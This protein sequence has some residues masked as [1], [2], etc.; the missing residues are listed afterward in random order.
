MSI[1]NTSLAPA[2][3]HQDPTVHA[4][5]TNLTD[6]VIRI[7]L[8]N[9]SPPSSQD[10]TYYDDEFVRNLISADILRNHLIPSLIYVC[11]LCIIGIPGNTLVC[12]V[13]HQKW[14]KRKKTSTLFILALSW[15]D[16]IN[17]LF[18]LPFEITLL[19]NLKSFDHPFVC[20]IS[21]Y[22]T[23]FFN[24]SSSVVLMGIAIDRFIGIW[25]SFRTK[26]FGIARA[27]GTIILALFLSLVTT[28][29]TLVMY[30]TMSGIEYYNGRLIITKT[31]S[32]D[33][34]FL[35]PDKLRYPFIYGMYLL[36]SNIIMDTI[37][38]VIYTLIGSKICRRRRF[39]GG[40]Q[41]TNRVP[42]SFVFNKKR[43]SVYSYTS[44][45][46]F[47][48]ET[49]SLTS[50][51]RNKINFTARLVREDSLNISDPNV[52]R[53]GSLRHSFKA[54]FKFPSTYSVPEEDIS[55][56]NP[57]EQNEEKQ[58]FLSVERPIRST[59]LPNCNAINQ[60]DKTSSQSSKTWNFR[61]LPRTISNMSHASSNDNN[62][63]GRYGRTFH[64]GKTTF[65]LFLVTLAY[66]LTFVPYC[67][68]NIMNK[69]NRTFYST[70]TD[71]EKNFNQLFFRSYLLSSAINPLIYSFLNR[72]F[73]QE[74][75]NIIRNI[76]CALKK[77]CRKS[78]DQW[79]QMWWTALISLVVFYHVSSKYMF[80]VDRLCQ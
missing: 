57:I 5:D 45:T 54:R 71:V 72:R 17:N 62:V 21:R 29:P 34:R 69:T 31:C 52:L 37:F 56:V 76:V 1:M 35:T 6:G 9:Y 27:K 41:T 77:R 74:C 16:L 39:G 70:R 14:R 15:F 44:S 32:V 4:Y 65:M 61:R 33:D 58:N 2:S 63:M 46:G 8:G 13:Y 43:P 28:W 50:V 23:F 55:N 60:K 20:R 48:E 73:R 3:L 26:P 19:I 10:M 24:A 30:G 51:S 59:S 49:T 36:G 80:T 40:S 78:V 12:Y 66:I 47:D 22:I 11:L 42:T 64:T 53:Y 68:I 25:C 75:S 7:P 18:T 67:I 38:I 79:K